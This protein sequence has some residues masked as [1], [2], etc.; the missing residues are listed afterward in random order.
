[1][2]IIIGS[3]TYPLPNGVTNSINTSVDGFVAAGHEVMLIA[4]EYDIKPV[5]PEHR[6][7]PGS[8]FSRNAIKLAGVMGKKELIFSLSAGSEIRQ[9]AEDFKPDAYWLH[10]VTYASNVFERHVVKSGLP[11]VLTYHTLLDYYGKTYFGRI[12]EQAMIF[13]S[14][15]VAN[16]VD[17]VIAPSQYVKNRLIKWGVKKPIEV[18]ATGIEPI[19]KSL[20]PGQLHQKFNIPAEHQ[21]LLFVGRVVKEKNIDSLLNMLKQLVKTDPKVTLLLI[22]PGDLEE[23][24]T[25]AEEMG[26]GRNIVLSGQVPQDET[27]QCYGAADVFVFASQSETQGLVIGEAML[28][29]LP[30][31]ALV[32]PI[33]PEVYPEEVAVVVRNE[34]DF[35]TAVSRLLRDPIRSQSLKTK[36]KKFVEENFSKRKMI[37][38]Q[39]ALFTGLLS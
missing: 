39:I 4:P 12:G 8:S 33:Q 31:A 24:A 20:T 26:I 5:R 16:N 3:Q 25:Q 36:A 28:A 35:A 13:R 1:M 7:V 21:V 23:T 11:S 22:G 2:R 18:I 14:A 29:E 17:K 9:L 30:V 10:Q 37:E 19:E 34:R 15:K 6:V 38:K 27:R 32:S